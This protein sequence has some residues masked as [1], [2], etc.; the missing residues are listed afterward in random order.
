MNHDSLLGGPKTEQLI[1]LAK[2]APKSGVFIEVGVYK[3]GSL[4]ALSNAFPDRIM[5][6]FDTFAGLP[7]RYYGTD[8]FHPPGD[9]AD[10]DF[11]RVEQL[12]R[13][14]NVEIVRGIFPDPARHRDMFRG[15]S[16]AFAHLDMDHWRGTL[17]ALIYIW[18]RLLS[19]G[20]IV[21]DDYDWERCPGIA[22]VVQTWAG[23]HGDAALEIYGTQ[24]ALIFNGGR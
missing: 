1:E 24:A 2:R 7:Q 5:Y 18:P 9:F 20:I 4:K 17:E 15:R 6:G 21:F 8:E 10:T 19:G 13:S 11:D 14:T 23:A 22:P 12:F 16:I 3:G